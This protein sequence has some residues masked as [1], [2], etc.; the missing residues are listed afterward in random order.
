MLGRHV[1]THGATTDRTQNAVMRHMP[2]H[3]ANRRALEAAFR[4]RLPG[5]T[6]RQNQCHCGA[7]SQF[8]H[9]QTF[10]CVT[11]EKRP[12]LRLVANPVS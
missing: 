5:Q 6:S 7:Q 8:S 10:L 12:S 3:A 4:L 9:T 11:G 2:G 1:V